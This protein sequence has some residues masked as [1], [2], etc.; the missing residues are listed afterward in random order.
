MATIR[1]VAKAAGVSVG[2]VSKVINNKGS[3]KNETVNH[4]KKIM[5]ELDYHPNQIARALGS[6]KSNTIA[7]I[8]PIAEI[9]IF[10][11][12]AA[13]IEKIAYK[14]GYRVILNSSFLNIEKEKKSI[15]LLRNN[16]IDGIIY[17]GFN[18]DVSTFSDIDIPVVTIGRKISKDIAV[19]QADTYM[20]GKIAA[21]HLI[22]CGCKKIIYFTEYPTGLGLDMRYKGLLEAAQKKGLDIIAAEISLERQISNNLTDVISQTIMNHTDADGIIAETDII[23]MSC[24]QTCVN[25]GIKVPEDMKIIGYGKHFYSMYTNPLLTTIKEPIDKIAEKAVLNLMDLINGNKIK[26]EFLPVSLVVGRTT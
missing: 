1:D 19:S 16:M 18:Y 8:M 9:P 20:A 4:I 2:T 11:L 7:L 6:R 21:T 24:V 5:E 25:L 12:Y 22:T 3:F 23:A 15:E 13:E 14:Y 10:G 26:D 17:A